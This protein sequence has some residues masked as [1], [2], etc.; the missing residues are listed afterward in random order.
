MKRD[1]LFGSPSV[2]FIIDKSEI[3]NPLTRLEGINEYITRVERKSKIS[4]DFE[5]PTVPPNYVPNYGL[6]YNRYATTD[7]RKLTSSDDFVVPSESDIITLYEHIDTY[8]FDGEYLS[9]LGGGKLKES[10]V[11]HWLTP[12][13]DGTNNYNFNMRGSG[14]RSA[15]AFE[16]LNEWGSLMTSD[17]A[18]R[19]GQPL[20]HINYNFSYDSAS[21]GAGYDDFFTGY[22]IRLVRQATPAELLL[23]DATACANY[24]GNDL[25][26][27]T[28]TKIG[29]Q[30]WTTSN[31]A[32]TKFRNGNYIP[33][34]DNGL[35]TIFTN[36][37]WNNLTSA[38]VCAF[39]NNV[40]LI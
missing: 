36:S 13:T 30:V 12:N 29:T 28:T 9:L 14:I 19:I 17:D 25:K 32:E 18:T 10:G 11:L 31:L 15:S 39:N 1:F 27:Y 33:G 2:K 21:S 23:A 3:K 26:Q 6:L 4:P 24:V 40:N 22:S 16:G 38:G 34:F 8:E 5:F 20:M 7:T 35:Y 37:E